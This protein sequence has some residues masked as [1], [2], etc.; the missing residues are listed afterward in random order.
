MTLKVSLNEDGKGII[1]IIY[2][3]MSLCKVCSLVRWCAY[4]NQYEE[5]SITRCGY[6]NY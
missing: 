3:M 4:V 1:N 5:Y 6:G 2:K